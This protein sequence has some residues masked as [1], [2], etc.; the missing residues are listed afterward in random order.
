MHAILH[1]AT[2]D[3]R[4]LM[5]G[6]G[7]LGA[8]GVAGLAGEPAEAVTAAAR[9]PKLRRGSRSQ[10]VLWM[11]KR[12]VAAKCW[13]GA[14]TTYFGPQCQQAVY[15]F[16]K[17]NGLYADGVVGPQTWAGLFAPKPFVP[18]ATSGRWVEIDLDKQLLVYVRHGRVVEIH[19]TST[20]NG[21]GYWFNGKYY[22]HA[23]TPRGTWYSMWT[24]GE[25]GWRHGQ[26][27]KM[28][29]PWFFAPGGYAI[30]GSTF[31]PPYPDSHGCARLTVAAMN[32]FISYGWIR[33]DRNL[34]I[35]GTG[36]NQAPLGATVRAAGAGALP[37]SESAHAADL[38]LT[39]VRQI[40]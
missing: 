13:P 5:L 39:S 14:M 28:W 6:A 36:P 32:R 25:D 11:K 22:P 3:R 31:I 19:N 24:T 29:R 10:Y 18:R 23:V 38:G 40:D 20:G 17:T 33:G 35:Y 37:P 27:G 26:L 8:V 15:A 16:Q 12:L 1:D 34:R 21:K 2:V 9:R 30:H 7:A 4:Q